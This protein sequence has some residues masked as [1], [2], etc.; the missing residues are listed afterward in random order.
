[1]QRLAFFGHG[2]RLLF[3]LDLEAMLDPAQEA[4]GRLEPP[5]ILVRQEFQF[6]QSPNHP[7]GARL[8]Q[9]RMPRRVQQLQRLH[10]ELD[11]PNSARAQFH[12]PLPMLV[13][14]N[15][16]LD[17]ELDRRDFVEQIR[18]RTFRK[19][20]RLELAQIIVSQLAIAADPARFDQGQPLPHLAEAGV[21]I[22]HALERTH[23]RSGAPS[24]RRRRSTRKSEP[25]GSEA[26]KVSMIL[27]PS[28]VNHS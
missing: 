13:A 16:A 2:V 7:Q 11:L 8:L 14:D 19:N 26:A 1:M 27:F 5:R 24:G 18:R 22:F 25:A 21:I 9:K 20:K 12:I 3:G 28:R 23:E 4:V 10:H 17:P 6:R 15:V